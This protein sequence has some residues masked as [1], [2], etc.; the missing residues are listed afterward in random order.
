MTT[1]ETDIRKG[2]TD[3]EERDTAPALPCMPLLLT[4][5]QAAALLSLSPRKVWELAARAVDRRIVLIQATSAGNMSAR[6]AKIKSKADATA[7]LKAGGELEVSGWKK[8]GRRWR[9]KTVPL[10][11]EDMAPGV[12]EHVAKF[13]ALRSA[14][15]GCSLPRRHRKK[16]SAEF[17]LY[18]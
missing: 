5:E 15:P 12:P 1:N 14:N 16:K 4:E 11:A 10:R 2:T 9:V 7:W 13:E 18:Y 6:L 17:K 8:R 3:T